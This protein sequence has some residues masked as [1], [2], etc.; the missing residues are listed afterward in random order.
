MLAAQRTI[1]IHCHVRTAACEELV[2]GQYKPEL[3]PFDRYGG[4]STDYNR[5]H[6]SE[7][8]PQLTLAERRLADMDRMG[9][10]VQAL[11]VAP[12][13]FYYWTD[14]ALGARLSRMENDRLAELVAGHPDRFVGLGTVPLQDVDSAINELDY[15]AD[16]LGFTGIEICSNV[17]G[18]DLDDR[19]FRR[20]FQRVEELDLL[21]VIHPHGFTQGDRFGDYYLVNVVG[22]P[23]DSTLAVS[24]LI[25]SGVLDAH[26]DL[27]ICVVHGGG[28][29]PFYTARMDHAW[30]VRP[31]CRERIS[32]P[33]STYLHRLSF[34]SVV[35]DEGML[36]ALVQR[37]GADHVLLGTDYPYDMGEDDPVGLVGQVPGLTGA[38]R[39]AML[40]GNAARLLRLDGSPQAVPSDRQST[41]GERV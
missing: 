26:P 30:R 15:I 14:P 32:Q 37:F 18:L 22:N 41:G 16:Q 4:A 20:F 11:S 38:D 31:E 24:R 1:D 13:Q 17:A 9:I 40:G 21:I 6:F 36:T 28:F 33:P 23:L 29:L 19:R 2:R 35:F 39:A 3:E 34:D 27:K 7:I 10:D 25:F 8:V 5:R 12:P